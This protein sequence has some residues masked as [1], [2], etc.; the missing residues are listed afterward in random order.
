MVTG[1][2][3]E[4]GETRCLRRSVFYILKPFFHLFLI[5][6]LSLPELPPI[7]LSTR[8]RE[9]ARKPSRR[10]Y[11]VLR[12]ANHDILWCLHMITR[13]LPRYA[14]RRRT[15]TA[16]P[17]QFESTTPCSKDAQEKKFRHKP[18]VNALIW[19]WQTC[20][21]RNDK[22]SIFVGIWQRVIRVRIGRCGSV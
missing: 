20:S 15:A 10:E 18:S 2:K 22:W 13:S 7:P 21:P 19:L 3:K 6:S 4:Q 12:C 17:F 14:T 5:S 11:N 8:A 16:F 1:E 9:W